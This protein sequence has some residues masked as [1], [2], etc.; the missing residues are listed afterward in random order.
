MKGL[1]TAVHRDRYEVE[2]EKEQI[3]AKLKTGVY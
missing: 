1:I 2:V 3:Y